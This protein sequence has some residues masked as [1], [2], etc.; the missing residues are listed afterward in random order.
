MNS[1][2]SEDVDHQTITCKAML[3]ISSVRYQCNISI[4]TKCA[5]INLWKIPICKYLIPSLIREDPL[6]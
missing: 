4:E 3:E 2:F 5:K 6:L 1:D